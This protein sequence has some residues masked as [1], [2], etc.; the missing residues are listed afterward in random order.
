MILQNAQPSSLDQLDVPFNMWFGPGTFS[1]F[2][3]SMYI[4]CKKEHSY[5]VR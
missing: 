1:S 2:V 3:R 5:D 4:T